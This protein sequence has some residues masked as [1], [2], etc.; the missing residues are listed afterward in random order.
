MIKHV[1]H[2]IERV[3]AALEAAKERLA[4]AERALAAQVDDGSKLR[5]AALVDQMR[6]DVTTLGALVDSHK[7]T[8][9]GIL[10]KQ[11]LDA[12]ERLASLK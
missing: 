10:E 11:A 8:L 4:D 5:A 9:R 7:A 3:G 1:E 2:E 6:A 12:Q